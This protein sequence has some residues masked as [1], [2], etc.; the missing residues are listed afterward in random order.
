MSKCKR[1]DE[2]VEVKVSRDGE[3][4]YVE[5]WKLRAGDAILHFGE[6]APILVGEDAH[7]SEDPCYD[8]WLFYDNNGNSYYPEDFGAGEY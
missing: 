6:A 2:T 8:G 7:Q 1:F 3:E 4:M 5:F